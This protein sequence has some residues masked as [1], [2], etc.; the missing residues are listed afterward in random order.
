MKTI[1]I[2]DL[3]RIRVT[4]AEEQGMRCADDVRCRNCH[5]WGYNQGKLINNIGQSRCMLRKEKADSYQWCQ[6]FKKPIDK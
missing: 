6:R 5:H 1:T 3:H 2:K 4:I